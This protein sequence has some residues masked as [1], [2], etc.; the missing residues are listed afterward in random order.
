MYRLN[1]VRM[2]VSPGASHPLGLDVVRYDLVVIREGR[3]ADCA[4]PVLLPDLSV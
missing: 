4:L 2:V 3:S 1:V